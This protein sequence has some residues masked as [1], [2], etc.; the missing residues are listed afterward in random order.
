MEVMTYISLLNSIAE[1]TT[2][3]IKFEIRST[4]VGSFL[5]GKTDKYA[6]EVYSN[7]NSGFVVE[8]WT[9]K[10]EYNSKSQEFLTKDDTCLFIQDLLTKKS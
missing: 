3:L 1:K 6:L 10:E 5:Y 4:G 8:L 2:N 9:G 7:D